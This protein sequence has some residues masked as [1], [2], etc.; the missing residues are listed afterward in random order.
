VVLPVMA[1]PTP[2]NLA[3]IARI[4]TIVLLAN[5]TGTLLA[6]VFCTFTPV[7]RSL[8]PIVIL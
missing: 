5:L 4:W 1:E 7:L 6:A 8:S 2:R 3:L